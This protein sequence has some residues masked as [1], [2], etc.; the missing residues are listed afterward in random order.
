M[1]RES[2]PDVPR[3]AVVFGG[4][5][6][7][8]EVSLASAQSAIAEMLSLGWDVLSAGV[9]RDGR[10]YV[11]PDALAH[12]VEGADSG[13]LPLSLTTA[14]RKAIDF[15]IFDGP[16]PAE[17]FK[18]HPVAFPICH[19]QWGEDGTLQ[20]FLLS[21][22]LRV[23]GVG[24]TSSA[25]CFDKRLSKAVLTAAGV[26]VTPGH[27]VTAD[28]WATDADGVVSEVVQLLGTGPWFVKPNRGGSSIGT[29]GPVERADLTSAIDEALR[30]DD[31]VLVE[32]F[33]SHRELMVGVMRG[34]SLQVS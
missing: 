20:G 26:P 18:N 31:E 1:S 9:G 7:E 23:I 33:I 14:D 5:S 25:L 3:V 19:G 22:G 8:H 11:G 15:E 24:V 16:P 30:F 28:G 21:Y 4:P 34:D 6:T 32:Q 13:R 27:H 12:L 17:V 29:V 2:M 10:W